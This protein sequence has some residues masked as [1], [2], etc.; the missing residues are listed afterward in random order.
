M[1]KLLS[2]L[3]LA[4]SCVSLAYGQSMR[5]AIAANADLAAGIYTAYTVTEQIATPAPRGFKPFYISHYGR[6]GSRNQTAPEKYTRPVELLERAEKDGKLTDL[7]ADVL[8][9]V[10]IIAKDAYMREGDL[11]TV[12]EREHR[13]IAERMMWTYPEVFKNKQARHINCFSTQSTRSILSM[14]AF[15]ERLKEIDPQLSISRYAS[16]HDFYFTRPDKGLNV[17][18]KEAR[19]VA[20]EYQKANTKDEAFIRRLFTDFEYAKEQI[21]RIYQS[22]GTYAFMGNMHDLA[23][24]IQ[25]CDTLQTLGLTLHDIFTDDERYQMWSLFNIR[26]YLTYGP[27]ADYGALRTADGKPL[28]KDIIDR[29]DRVISGEDSEEIATLRFGHDSYIIPLLALLRVEGCD[30]SIPFSEIERLPEVWCDSRITS[31]SVNVQFIFFRNK[32]GEVLVKLLHSEKEVKI[33]LQTDIFPFYRW[34]DFRNYCL[35]LCKE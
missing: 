17:I 18:Y 26:R 34:D 19:K 29:A 12:G 31:M 28:L 23:M 25:N 33:P 21:C 6:H 11:T 14:A 35:E 10:R 9:R 20:F 4:I 24:I 2:T 7:G 27:S 30:G 8:K 16:A 32:Q 1:H 13:G 22:D 5:Q 3:L 15:T